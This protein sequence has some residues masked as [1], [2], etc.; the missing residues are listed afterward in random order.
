MKQP[1]DQAV[2]QDLANRA[3]QLS[4]DSIRA[5]SAAGS[6]H[7][8]SCMSAAELIAVIF[9]YVMK[10]NPAQPKHQDNDRFILSKGHAVPVVYAAY[11]QLG[12]ISDEELL[13]LRKV[14]SVL[15]GHPTPRFEYNEAATGSLGQGLSVGVGMALA[16]RQD[17]Y[18]YK[19][20]VMMGDGEIAE[21]SIWEAA[22][23]ASRYKLDNLIGVVD[24]NRLA[25]SEESI[26]GH[27]V[28]IYRKRFEAFGWHSVIVD[29]H[30]I[31]EI[32]IAFN[33]AKSMHGLPFMIIAKTYK[34]HGLSLVEDKVGHHGKPFKEQIEKLCADLA[35]QQ[36]SP[37][38]DAS[39]ISKKERVERFSVSGEF[40]IAQDHQ[41]LLAQDKKC[42]TRKAFGLGLAALGRQRDDVVVLDADVKN[43]TFTEL[44]E[45]E[46][47]DR[48]VQCF[49]AEQNM[50]GVATGFEAR[51][52]IPFAATFGAFFAR[53]YDHIRMAG[54]GQNALR[55][56]GSHCG[57]SIGEDGPSQM[58]LEDL[59]MMAAVPNSIILYPSDAV[60]AYK[61]VGVMANYH[62]GVSYMR[63][64]RA[65]TP[66]LY[67]HQEVFSIGGCKVLRQHD[68]AQACIIAAGI[69]LHEALKAAEE[70]EKQGVLVSVID[71]YSV[72]PLDLET[73]LSVA[74]KSNNNIITVEDHYLYGGLGQMV[75]HAVGNRGMTVKTMAVTGISRSGKP[76]ELLALSG[77]DAKAIMAVVTK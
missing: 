44:F 58:A 57:V 32:C 73:I 60:A 52:K 12:I 56:C 48:F 16:A 3:L 53:A 28:E 46:H 66:I 5:T 50:V 59:A 4:I 15:E 72:K 30:S 37:V 31:D 63:S 76:D 8:T 34:G 2:K 49:I 33:Q 18:S 67:D 40:A 47:S 9:F 26:C 13:T 71:L 22:E 62:D 19:T 23:L 39:I 43:S 25:Q 35:E 1:C 42:S 77:I 75:V 29:G 7:P 70:L 6:G 24:A 11:K 61:L 14:D 68:N 17:N 54:I 45:K 55:L 21:G 10:Y 51:G 41:E 69:T 74:Q 38:E 27:D 36:T 20:I 65:D 64:T